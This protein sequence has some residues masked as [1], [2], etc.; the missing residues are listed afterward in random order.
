[1]YAAAVSSAV[2]RR[3]VSAPSLTVPP[4]AAPQEAHSLEQVCGGSSVFPSAE[5]TENMLMNLLLPLCL[6]VGCGRSGERARCPGDLTEPKLMLYLSERAR[7]PG[8]LTEPK[9][10]L[11]LTNV[12]FRTCSWPPLTT[13]RLLRQT[14]PRCARR[15][16][17]SR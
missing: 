14:C 8:D 2:R 3:P 6:R 10:I 5:K 12:P 7:C 4:A 11:C 16:S 1:M 13:R 15:T 9:L 17:V